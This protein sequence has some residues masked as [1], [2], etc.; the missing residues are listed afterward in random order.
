MA[1]SRK[2]TSE[3]KSS[4]DAVVFIV[5]DQLSGGRTLGAFHFLNH[6]EPILG[7]TLNFFVLSYP[8]LSGSELARVLSLR[9]LK[10]E[11]T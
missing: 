11:R 8:A 2:G 7:C 5:F 9:S 3:K 1:T 10:R 6:S 4:T